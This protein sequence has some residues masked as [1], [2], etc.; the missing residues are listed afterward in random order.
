MGYA[1]T[2]TASG[3]PLPPGIKQGI[4]AFVSAWR[5][6]MRPVLILALVVVAAVF[7]VSSCKKGESPA[8]KTGTAGQGAAAQVAGEGSGEP[9]AAGGKAAG[10]VGAESGKAA[11]EAVARVANRQCAMRKKNSPNLSHSR[12][13]DH[14][15]SESESMGSRPP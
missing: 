11:G 6:A 1:L 7:A 8:D 5:Y 9:G 13:P 12:T 4:I 3:F 2:Q 14:S 10:E 15:D